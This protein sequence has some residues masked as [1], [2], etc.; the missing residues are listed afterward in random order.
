MSKSYICINVHSRLFSFCFTLPD[1]CFRMMGSGVFFPAGAT[2]P[3]LI[4]L[5][6]ASRVFSE[7][8]ISV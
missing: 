6:T 7:A 3:F 8:L 5:R 1:I 4:A 2:S